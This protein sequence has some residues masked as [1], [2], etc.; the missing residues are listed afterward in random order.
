MSTAARLLGLLDLTR[1]ERP[2]DPEQIDALVDRAVTPAGAV[3]AVCLYPEWLGRVVDPL[4][5]TGVRIAA[6]ANFPA[7]DDDAAAAAAEAEAAVRDGAGEV[8][9]VVPWRAHLAGDGEAIGRVVQACRE[10]VGPS[11]ALKAILEVGSLG[12]GATVVDAS[13]RA[14]AA[15]ADFLKTSTGKVGPG[16]N[17]VAARA[18]LEAI[19]DAGHGGFKASGG[20]RTTAQA[21]PYLELAERMLG[22]DWVTAATFRIGASSLLDDLLAQIPE[23]RAP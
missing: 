1:L 23:G 8:D 20:V 3:A 6:V 10:A 21:L 7:G 11:V 13:D 12:D 17:L 9:V 18:M 16:A 14:L 4:A 2:D 5:G 19:R 22:P 15:G